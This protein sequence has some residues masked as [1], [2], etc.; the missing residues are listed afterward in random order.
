MKRISIG[1]RVRVIGNYSEVMMHFR[2]SG[3]EIEVELISER[4]CQV[5]VNGKPY[6]FP[7]LIGEGGIH[8]DNEGFYIPQT[9]L[10]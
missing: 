3:K 2:L 10:P 7:I 6:S 5:Y 8:R 1:Q 4:S 9:L